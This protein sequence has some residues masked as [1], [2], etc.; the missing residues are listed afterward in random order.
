[1]VSLNL[2]DLDEGLVRRK[3]KP[4]PLRKTL[5]PEEYPAERLPPI[6]R[7]AVQEVQEYIQAPMALVAACALAVVSAAVQARFDVRRDAV[8]TGPSS[9]YFLTVAESGE[10]KTAIDNLF[11][12]PLK[13]W[14]ARQAR[15]A[16][17]AK[18]QYEKEF[19]E[20]EGA[21]KNLVILDEHVGTAFD[22]K[23]LHEARKPK[24]P[25]ANQMLRG[26]D[27][28]EAL[29]ISMQ[30]YPVAAVLSAEA[31]MI[32]GAHSMGADR[33]MGNLGTFNIMW[34]GGTLRQNRVGRDPIHVERPRA[35]LGLMVQPAVLQNFT[36]RTGNL[37][38]GIGYFARF[39]FSQPESTQGSRFYHAP[40]TDMPALRA[41]HAQVAAL[42][43]VP[44]EFDEL[45]RLA[46]CEVLLDPQAQDCWIA[47]HNEVEEQLGGRDSFAGIKDVA[48]KAAENAARLACCYHTFE[49]NSASPIPHM[50]M[51]RACA[52]MRWYL[53]EAVRFGQV[54]EVTDELRNAELLEEWLVEQWKRGKGDNMTVNMVR[55]MGPNALRGG[56]RV[57][58][59]VEVLVD[60]QR[61]H[62]HQP[63][64]SKSRRIVVNAEVLK[65]YT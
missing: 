54:T 36:Q 63:V 33:A 56:R 8:L 24:E 38:K 1:M 52:A 5:K 42:L 43:D 22:P 39:L 49:T 62:V 31:G 34:D 20:W 21:G 27:T 58:D 61:I 16:R 9:L 48:S 19:E 46:P 15:A 65:E 47:F 51:D 60:H 59:A 2:A 11:M 28:T 25:R 10:R 44:A 18:A 17:L 55:Q 26:D 3:L 7:D 41:F 14:Q 37:A 40:A 6:I 4:L 32:F 29:L 50:A 30:D 12:A 13:E 23:L 35:T 45:D 57:D 53:D 64:G